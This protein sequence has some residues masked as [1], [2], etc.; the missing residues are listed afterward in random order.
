MDDFEKQIAERVQRARAGTSLPGAKEP[1]DTAST[2]LRG[3]VSILQR[4]QSAALKE[5]VGSIKWELGQADLTAEF[6][7]GGGVD[8]LVFRLQGDDVL[9]KGLDAHVLASFQK[10]AV[11]GVS[12][13]EGRQIL[14]AFGT[15]VRFAANEMPALER[16]VAEQL[17]VFFDKSAK[18]R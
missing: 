2:R 14:A 3:I 10:Q 16:A 7:G 17:L 18:G 4:A 5:G 13:P 8:R 9:V 12:I 1:P 6:A 15:D 11:S